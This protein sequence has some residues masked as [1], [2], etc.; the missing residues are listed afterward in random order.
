MPTSSSSRTPSSS[1]APAAAVA[2][3]TVAAAAASP[4]SKYPR[5]GKRG[6]PQ[7][8]PSKLYEILEG[9]NP[10]IVGWTATGRGFEV[11]DHARLSS[12]VLG[13]F[14]KQ[15]KFSSFQRQLNLYGFRKITKGSESGSYQHPHF[16]RGERTTL[17]TIRRSTKEGN[18]S[19]GPYPDTAAAAA[20]ATSVGGHNA[21]AREEWQQWPG[22]SN[23][24]SSFSSDATAANG[25][26]EQEAVKAQA[27]SALD[28]NDVE[29]VSLLQRMA[30]E[31]Q[32][33]P[34][35]KRVALAAQQWEGA[36]AQQAAAGESS[37]ARHAQQQQQQQQQQQA[38]FEKPRPA[39]AGSD[40]AGQTQQMVFTE[41]L[42]DI[43]SHE[44]LGAGGG[45][46][47]SQ[48]ARFLSL[49]FGTEGRA[50]PP[51]FPQKQY[52][53][54]YQGAG[55]P[56]PFGSTATTASCSSSPSSSSA[57]SAAFSHLP[58]PSQLQE[59]PRRRQDPSESVESTHRR[60]GEGEEGTA[61]T[62]GMVMSEQERQALLARSRSGP[63]AA[64][65]AAVAAAEQDR[66][67][68]LARPRT[69]PAGYSRDDEHRYYQQ[70]QDAGYMYDRSP[71]RSPLGRGGGFSFGSGRFGSGA[72]QGSGGGALPPLPSLNFE[73]YNVGG[74][75]GGGGGPVGVGEI[76][77]APWYGPESS[78]APPPIGSYVN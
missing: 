20:P 74:G 42:Y 22:A 75:G 19:W 10:D 5:F 36:R 34:A 37:P 67:A 78:Y 73:Q 60:G 21:A 9:E 23:P 32:D 55:L 41:R 7:A 76:R 27:Q 25:N 52:Q 65:A 70:Q 13:R 72:P 6:A 39:P 50:A 1:T 35:R 77:R 45:A 40:E 59:Q 43:L 64:A 46:A 2:A 11:R 3:P 62:G 12:E 31:A 53:Q 18:N 30:K 58:L 68:L 71:D 63:S 26:A 38:R 8:F 17:L 4:A 56:S 61:A 16:R 15:D 24:S 29:V 51:G 48:Q 69:G 54:H 47:A 49:A 66:Q 28:Q 44:R 14:F 57:S 33:S